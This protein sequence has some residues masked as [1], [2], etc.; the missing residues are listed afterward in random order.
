M[1]EVKNL[2]GVSRTDPEYYWRY[3]LQ[4]IVTAKRPVGLSELN[5][6]FAKRLEA[7]RR[8]TTGGHEHWFDT[9]VN[10]WCNY[11]QQQI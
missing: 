8:P 10:R 9:A 5:Q 3:C 1:A 6:L 4:E 11:S 2:M 7:E